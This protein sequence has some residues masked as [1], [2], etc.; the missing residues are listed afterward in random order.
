MVRKFLTKRDAHG[1]CI[2]RGMFLCVMK[3]GLIIWLSLFFL[4]QK[5]ALLC[6]QILFCT[7]EFGE[8]KF[9][10]LLVRHTAIQQKLFFE[11][12]VSSN[13]NDSCLN[14]NKIHWIKSN[15]KMKNLFKVQLWSL[16][17]RFNIGG[18]YYYYFFILVKKSS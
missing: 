1:V 15:E 4:Q 16:I 14:K 13:A 12:N 10:K 9:C 5:Q 3:S 17:H 8:R 2:R 6:I 18:G 7:R 11:Q